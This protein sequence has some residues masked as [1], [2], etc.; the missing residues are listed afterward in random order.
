VAQRGVALKT[1]R[2]HNIPSAV[3]GNV[4]D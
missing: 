4:M 1:R 3:H 2:C